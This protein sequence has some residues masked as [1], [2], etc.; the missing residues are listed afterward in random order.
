MNGDVVVVVDV[1]VDVVG[2]CSERRNEMG[3]R[4]SIRSEGRG[5]FCMLRTSIAGRFRPIDRTIVYSIDIYRNF[6]LY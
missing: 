3:F 6:Y 1:S 4:I 2:S 5:R